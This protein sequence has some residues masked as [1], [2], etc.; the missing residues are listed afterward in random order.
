V[1]S[2]RVRTSDTLIERQAGDMAR[3]QIA[4]Q[5]LAISIAV[6]HPAEWYIPNADVIGARDR[7]RTSVQAPVRSTSETLTGKPCS[8]GSELSLQIP[9]PNK[10][11]KSLQC[12]TL[13]DGWFKSF[14]CCIESNYWKNLGFCDCIMMRF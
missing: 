3:D 8:S 1:R 14:R 7:Q 9:A 12:A 5:T 13:P 11:L 6:L 2:A 10:N 4:H